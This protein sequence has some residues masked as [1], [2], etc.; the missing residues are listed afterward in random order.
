MPSKT[1]NEKVR[2]FFVDLCLNFV[3]G[4]RA[5][6]L[7]PP[8][9]PE[10]IKKMDN[11]FERLNRYLAQRPSLAMLFIHGDV[12]VENSPLPELRDKLVRITKLLEAM[13][14]QR[15]L[16]RRGL[17]QAELLG[18]M[19]LILPLLKN[20]EGA[21]L[22]LAR[23]QGRLPHI[24]A[25]ALPLEA[26]PKVS[27]DEVSSAIQA[28]RDV[29]LSFS[30][31]L[32]DLFAD[33]E[34]PLAPAKLSSAKEITEEIQGMVLGGD[35][36]LK[37]LIYRRSEDPDPH[38]HAIN[39]CA[40]SMALGREMEMEESP[41]LDVGLAALLHDV[42]WY[43]PISANFKQT[44]AITLD[45]R[46][47]QWE[48]PVLGAE[49]LLATPN[50]PDL[51]P[52]VAYEHHIH[53]DGTGFPKQERPR[54]LNFAS[55]ITCITNTYDNLRRKRPGSTAHS[56][57]DSLNWMDRKAGTLFHPLVYQCF[58]ALVKAQAEEDL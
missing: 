41:V 45:E 25:G 44:Q 29:V 1:K 37:T 14:L 24:Q 58:R 18:F 42:G 47:R 17:T 57:K 49:I 35:M 23:N 15:I 36:P 55:L 52:V 7:Y 9:H 8:Q 34:G 50:M 19:Q 4:L 21:D 13:K 40:L 28:A 38:I 56:L 5:L 48:H 20:P 6:S 2:S 53:Y 33:I 3:G 22:V 12:V 46:K 10:T 39:V 43:L 31:Q 30:D 26:G 32:K 16:F 51:A 11:L 54:D 27:Y